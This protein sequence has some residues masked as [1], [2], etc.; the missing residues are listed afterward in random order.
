LLDVPYCGGA[1]QNPVRAI[2][3]AQDVRP[4]SAARG[5][6]GEILLVGRASRA[7]THCGWGAGQTPDSRFKIPDSRFHISEAML[8]IGVRQIKAEHTAAE[9]QDRLQI[10]DSRFK[11]PKSRF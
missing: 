8:G 10:Q 3:L 5:H 4:G 7:S 1:L 6:E 2:K 11:I 9:A